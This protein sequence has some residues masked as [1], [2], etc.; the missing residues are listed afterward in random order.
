M[1]VVGTKV[2]PMC[3]GMIGPSVWRNNTLKEINL[4]E[5][6]IRRSDQANELGKTLDPL[7][8]LRDILAELSN[9]EALRYARQVRLVVFRLRESIIDTNDEMKMLNRIREQLERMH[10]HIRKD[11]V[12]NLQSQ[13]IRTSRPGR[14]KV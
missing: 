1:A 4:S 7:P 13:R 14:E 3:A 11:I 5:N 10:E 2:I 6:V 8:H 9:E 12:V